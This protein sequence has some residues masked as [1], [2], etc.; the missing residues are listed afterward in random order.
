[1]ARLGMVQVALLVSRGCLPVRFQQLF[2]LLDGQE[3]NKH[4]DV[5]SSLKLVRFS[6]Q[7]LFDFG[8]RTSELFSEILHDALPLRWLA[9]ERRSLFHQICNGY[10][11]RK[12]HALSKRSDLLARL[13]PAPQKPN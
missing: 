10:I 12:T 4:C 5:C 7:H 11:H 2:H 1:M 8:Y 6:A 13:L 9:L 3:W